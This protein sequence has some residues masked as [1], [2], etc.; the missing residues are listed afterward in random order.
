MRR[1]TV[2]LFIVL[3]ASWQ[4]LFASEARFLTC[5]FRKDQPHRACSR[6]CVAQKLSPHTRQTDG[7]SHRTRAQ[8]M[9]V[10][11]DETSWVSMD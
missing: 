6:W 2:S 7:P 9:T 3:A 4:P 10:L 5:V 11:F 1:P 8:Q